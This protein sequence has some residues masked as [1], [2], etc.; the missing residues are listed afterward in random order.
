MFFR[1]VSSSLGF[2]PNVNDIISTITGRSLSNVDPEVQI[3]MEQILRSVINETETELAQNTTNETE[4]N[5][6][7]EK[8]SAQYI[9]SRHSVSTNIQKSSI[10]GER[11]N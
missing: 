7:R 1:Y 10:Y 11:T 5:E 2:L 4:S 8:R 3:L 6:N 9:N